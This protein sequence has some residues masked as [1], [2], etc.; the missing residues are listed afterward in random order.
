[1][2]F[3]VHTEWTHCVNKVV[4]H[5]ILSMFKQ[6]LTRAKLVVKQLVVRPLML[7]L[8]LEVSVRSR[9]LKPIERVNKQKKLKIRIILGT[10]SQNL[11]NFKYEWTKLFTIWRTTL[12][13]IRMWFSLTIFEL[14]LVR[15]NL[16]LKFSLFFK[17]KNAEWKFSGKSILSPYISIM[18]FHIFKQNTC[19][20]FIW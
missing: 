7:S 9:V 2:T 8:N 12:K 14:L 6:W 11:N 16:T 13:K 1:M 5:K 17:T 19:T 3:D 4:V 18:R 15:V 20:L 10:T